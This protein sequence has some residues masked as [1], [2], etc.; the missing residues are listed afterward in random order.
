MLILGIVIVVMVWAL[1]DDNSAIF[2]ISFVIAVFVGLYV[3]VLS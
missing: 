2:G 1:Y 3:F